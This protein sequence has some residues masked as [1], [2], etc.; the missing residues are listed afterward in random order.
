MTFGGVKN[1]IVAKQP[2]HNPNPNPFYIHYE[3]QDLYS[4]E[5]TDDK[6]Q[7]TTF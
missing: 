5:A 6:I 1:A 7:V 2:N 4:S 3:G